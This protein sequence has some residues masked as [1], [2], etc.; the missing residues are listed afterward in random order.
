MRHR[1][2][3]FFSILKYDGY[4]H[5]EV[6]AQLSHLGIAIFHIRSKALVS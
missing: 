3:T 2:M 6:R 4:G 1:E 5:D